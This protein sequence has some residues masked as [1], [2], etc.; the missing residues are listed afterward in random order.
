MTAGPP[1]PRRRR[2]SASRS[3]SQFVC[4]K[5]GLACHGFGQ[6]GWTH[7]VAGQQGETPRHMRDSPHPIPR[8]EH[9]RLIDPATPLHPVAARARDGAGPIRDPGGRLHQ[10][11]VLSAVL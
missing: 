8:S 4:L 2:E 1:A 11:E 10:V 5:C 3:T 7:S 6:R 9:E